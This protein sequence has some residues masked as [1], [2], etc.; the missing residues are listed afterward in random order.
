M[1]MRYHKNFKD[2]SARRRSF[3]F[4]KYED[5]ERYI[6]ATKRIKI[7]FIFLFETNR[8]KTFYLN[9]DQ[10]Q[11]AILRDPYLF[12]KFLLYFIILVI[13]TWFVILIFSII[14]SIYG[15]NYYLAIITMVIIEE[16]IFIFEYFKNI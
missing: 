11:P 12:G 10:R 9:L 15:L 6:Y 16:Y 13:I 4:N 5:T 7:W 2:I 1:I 3:Y 14:L 8:R